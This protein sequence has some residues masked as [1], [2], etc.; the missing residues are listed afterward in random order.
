[1]TPFKALYGRD[2]PPLIRIG[3]GQTQVDSLEAHL[4]ERYAILDDL[5]VQLLRAQWKMKQL[6]DRKC[7]ELHLDEGSFVYLKLQPYR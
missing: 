2:P 6:A 1:M 3:H 7:R 5:R 4:Q